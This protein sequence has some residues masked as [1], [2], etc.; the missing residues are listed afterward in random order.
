MSDLMA[1]EYPARGIKTENISRWLG[2]ERKTAMCSPGDVACY[3][4]RCAAWATGRR[5]RKRFKTRARI[6]YSDSMVTRARCANRSRRWLTRWNGCIHYAECQL[7]GHATEES[8]PGRVEQRRC[9]ASGCPQRAPFDAW[10][11]IKSVVM[12]ESLRQMERDVTTERRY[13]VSSLAPD[14]KRLSEAIRRIG[15]WRTACTGAWVWCFMKTRAVRGATM[16]AIRV[17]EQSLRIRP[18]P[19]SGTRDKCGIVKRIPARQD[20]V[21]QLRL[22]QRPV[23]QAMYQCVNEHQCSIFTETP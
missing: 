7:G 1:W 17:L 15:K 13:F 8:G 3:V 21:F 23:I 22:E 2:R 4:R 10:S 5:S 18:H 16:L 9:M 6:T 20:D 12:L 19:L 14:S 11:G